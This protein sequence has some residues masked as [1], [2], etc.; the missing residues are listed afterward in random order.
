MGGG[1][2]RAEGEVP[3]WQLSR[4]RARQHGC[5][6]RVQSR[7][8]E[9]R[10]QEEAEMDETRM[11]LIIEKRVPFPSGKWLQESGGWG[12]GL[13]LFLTRS[14]VMRWS[15]GDVSLAGLRS[16][17]IQARSWVLLCRQFADVI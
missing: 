13:L 12:R 11:T 8:Q 17:V 9:G 15:A 6:K 10:F 14:G 3:G 2:G 5:G 16:S 1:R 7:P 4:L